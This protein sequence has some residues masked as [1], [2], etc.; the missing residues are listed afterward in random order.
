MVQMTGK[1]YLSGAAISGKV[2]KLTGTWL[3]QQCL[4]WPHKWHTWKFSVKKNLTKSIKF[5]SSVERCTILLIRKRARGN[6]EQGWSQSL[7]LLLLV[8]GTI[9]LKVLQ[10]SWSWWMTGEATATFRTL[11]PHSNTSLLNLWHTQLQDRGAAKSAATE[12]ESC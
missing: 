9:K 12:L 2:C 1:N 5:S 10:I 4:V 8:T 3:T 7:K 11:L 6:R